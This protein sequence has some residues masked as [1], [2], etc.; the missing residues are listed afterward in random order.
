MKQGLDTKVSRPCRFRD[1]CYYMSAPVSST[2]CLW[3]IMVWTECKNSKRAGEEVEMELDV[4]NFYEILSPRCTVLVSTADK[5]GRPNAAPFSFVTPVSANPP[6]V[7]IASAPN[8]HTLSNIRETGEFVLNIVP[9]SI[10]DKMWLCS[11]AFPKGVSEIK[12]AGL[13]ERK[14]KHVRAPSVEECAGWIECRLESEHKAGDHVL[15][16]GRVLHAGCHDDL[17]KG[18][19]FDVA[20]AKPVMHIRGKR[21][22]A[23]ERIV[24]VK[25]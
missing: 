10:L 19:Q 25:D 18:E 3:C 11:K 1:Y 8:R 9:E 21:F 13:T 17:M 20:R 22:V 12:E 14:S 6:L 15:I 7:L 23:A 16:V 4:A 2:T 5:Q 24:T